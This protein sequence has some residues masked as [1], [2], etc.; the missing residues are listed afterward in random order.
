MCVRHFA[1]VRRSTLS[2]GRWA[3]ASVDWYQFHPTLRT[4]A[5]VLHDDFRMHGTGV[6]LFLLALVLLLV[7]VIVSWSIEV[8][9]PYLPARHE[10]EQANE[11]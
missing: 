6:F 2:V 5:R 10:R 9:R 3:F 7:L 4:I 1:F 8:N 11:N